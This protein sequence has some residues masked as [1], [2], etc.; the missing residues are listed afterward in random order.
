[1]V[2]LEEEEMS[3]VSGAGLAFVFDNFSMRW[4]PTSFI[5]LTGTAAQGVGWQR[6]DARYYGLSIT[7]GAQTGGTDWYG[8]GCNTTSAAA[9]ALGCPLGNANTITTAETENDF[10]I[11]IGRA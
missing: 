2:A 6:G 8:N 3:G 7:N 5:E 9:G 11:E 1:M 4:A 10:G